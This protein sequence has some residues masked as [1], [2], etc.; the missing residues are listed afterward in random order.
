MITIRDK[1][2]FAICW[3]VGIGFLAIFSVVAGSLM[4]F[5]KPFSAIAVIVVVAAI[6]FIILGIARIMIRRRQIR[7]GKFSLNKLAFAYMIAII[8]LTIV[9]GYI[10]LMIIFFL[11]PPGMGGG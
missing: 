3:I 4:A 2:E 8:A 6:F 9:L 7:K 5:V 1:I 11:H 10:S